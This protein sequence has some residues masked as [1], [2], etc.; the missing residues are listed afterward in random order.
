MKFSVFDNLNGT[1]NVSLNKKIVKT[2]EMT[3]NRNKLKAFIG[4]FTDI[5]RNIRAKMLQKIENALTV[6]DMRNFEIG[7]SELNDKPAIVAYTTDKAVIVCCEGRNWKALGSDLTLVHAKESQNFVQQ[8]IG[9][10]I[11][12]KEEIEF[13]TEQKV[14]VISNELE[15]LR[16]EIEK[17]K[18]EK[19]E[20]KKIISAYAKN[21]KGDELS[22]DEDLT[23]IKHQNSI[24]SEVGASET[25]SNESTVFSVTETA[26][27]LNDDLIVSI[28]QS[29]KENEM[30]VNM[31]IE[32]Y[33]QQEEYI[34]E[35][36]KLNHENTTLKASRK[37]LLKDLF[38]EIEKTSKLELELKRIKYINE[39]NG[40]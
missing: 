4:S 32:T 20:D 7:M 17:M 26:E 36:I 6:K 30:N 21:Y 33:E 40:K 38:A 16:K 14:D 9:D 39:L 10:F 13:P 35:I 31:T 18:K 12:I 25:V 8:Y 28:D 22:F 15:E 34:Q 11:E 3:N 37:S 5:H 2:N 24:K 29:N 19:A 1:T 27:N 23:I